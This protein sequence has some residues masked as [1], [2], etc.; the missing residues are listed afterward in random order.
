MVAQSL[1]NAQ[2]EI[3]KIFAS[4]LSDAEM[5]SLRQLLIDFRYQIL[6]ESIEKLN[7]SPETIKA[8]QTGHDRIPANSTKSQKQ[9]AA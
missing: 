5:E 2:L 7:L 8:W 6:Q 3:L 1:T 4:N 9:A